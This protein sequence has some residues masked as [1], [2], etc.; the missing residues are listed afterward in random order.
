MFLIS[1]W[2]LSI[3]K[4]SMLHQLKELA[5]IKVLQHFSSHYGQPTLI[6]SDNDSNFISR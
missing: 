5:C 2:A 1:I 4:I 3:P 6:I